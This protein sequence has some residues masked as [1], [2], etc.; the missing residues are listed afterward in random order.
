[1]KR[2]NL[3]IV[4]ILLISIVAIGLLGFTYLGNDDDIKYNAVEIYVLSWDLNTTGPGSEIDVQFQISI[5]S[6]G[7][8]TYEK[9]AKSQIFTDTTIETVPFRFGTT[10]PTTA[11][12]FFFKVDVFALVDGAQSL[13]IY[14][15][16][17]SSPINRGYNNLESVFSWSYDATAGGRTNDLACRISYIY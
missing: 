12:S 9:V 7:D 5:D 14:T 4:S 15:E 10:I 13:M 6:D 2:I 3:A 1:M 8:G 16:S 17:D 11:S